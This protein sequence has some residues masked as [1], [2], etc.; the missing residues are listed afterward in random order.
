LRQGRRGIKISQ[1]Q[2]KL[3]APEDEEMEFNMRAE[4]KEAEGHG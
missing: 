2:W 4:A 1:Y 3:V